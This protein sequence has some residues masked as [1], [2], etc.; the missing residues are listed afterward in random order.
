MIFHQTHAI[1]EMIVSSVG[2][3]KCF[4]KLDQ[5]R[6]DFSRARALRYP[7]NH[8]PRSGAR[9]PSRMQSQFVKWQSVFRSIVELGAIGDEG[10]FFMRPDRIRVPAA[11]RLDRQSSG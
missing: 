1:K 2:N 7:I 9:H 3:C 10:L 6:I 8:C 5:S 4:N 11:I